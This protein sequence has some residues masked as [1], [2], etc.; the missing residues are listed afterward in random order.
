MSVKK[1]FDKNKQAVTVG[2]Y[3]RLSAPDTLGDGIESEAHL[4]ASLQKQDYVLPPSLMKYIP[5]L[6]GL[7]KTV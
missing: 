5:L 1:L 7:S 2:K 3:L 4:K 6:Q